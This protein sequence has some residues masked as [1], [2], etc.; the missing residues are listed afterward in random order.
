MRWRTIISRE[1]V[2]GSL[3]SFQPGFTGIGIGTADFPKIKLGS[4]PD[5]AKAQL[6]KAKNLPHLEVYAKVNT[7]AHTASK[8]VAKPRMALHGL[9]IGLVAF[10]VFGSQ[11][12]SL[13]ARTAVVSQLGHS[14][15]YGSVLDAAA[16]ATVAANVAAKTNLL[17]SADATQQASHLDSQ[18]ALA[19]TDDA[20]AKR[21]IVSTA[22]TVRHDI[23]SYTIKPGDTLSSIA[24]QFNVTSDT[25]KWANNID[26]VS[27]IKPGQALKI[28]PIT[29]LLYTVD[30]GDTTAS[31]AA[32]YQ[33]V[34]A[35]L[36]EYN[37]LDVK[38]LSAG[39][40]IIIPDGRIAEVAK[41]VTAAVSQ[42]PV[43]SQAVW[44]ALGSGSGYPWGQCTY[45][46]AEMIPGLPGNLGNA[47]QWRWTLPAYGWH[48]SS[49]PVPG[50]IAYFAYGGGGYGHVAYVHSVN[51][52]GSVLISERNF[53]GNPNV[54]YRT[55]G[56]YEA[57]YLVR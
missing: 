32:K 33:A 54:T 30:P 21:Q 20:L 10:V 16:S 35:Q 55:I 14:T 12:G 8:L 9:S 49:S 45:H 23:T 57:G 53:M 36:V 22:Q 31:I 51:S 4:K 39:K 15:G 41:P 44:F 56:A 26:D 34:E 19:G 40:Q 50:S 7:V 29:G 6:T 24:T 11:F 28:L 46:I 2:G 1:A 37:D 47:W 42:A 17:V 3:D 13:A 52:D 18:V 5:W 38:G 25:I 27:A 48:Y 43:K